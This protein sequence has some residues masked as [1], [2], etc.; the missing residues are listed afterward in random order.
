MVERLLFMAILTRVASFH[1][2]TFDV[3]DNVL[4][5][6]HSHLWN[7]LFNEY[8]PELGVEVVD[9]E[10]FAPEWFQVGSNTVSSTVLESIKSN[11]D[12]IHSWSCLMTELRA[13]DWSEVT[14]L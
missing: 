2:F 8:A 1:E 12:S 7:G 10:H 9:T 14:P 11:G 3:S 5:G 6:I 4:W 13:S